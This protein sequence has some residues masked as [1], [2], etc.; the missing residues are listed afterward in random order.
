MQNAFFIRPDHSLL[1]GE[2]VAV[3]VDHVFGI[4]GRLGNEH[5]GDATP[6][7][8]V[9]TAVGADVD[10]Q[11]RFGLCCLSDG[12]NGGV[13][14]GGLAI[15]PGADGDVA[16]AVGQ[17]T[18]QCSL[19][20]LLELGNQA[21]QQ[22]WV[23][24][25][26][27]VALIRANGLVA[28]L[29]P[30][31]EVL[32][33]GEH[34]GGFA[35]KGVG[36]G[37]TRERRSESVDLLGPINAFAVAIRVVLVDGGLQAVDR[38]GVSWFVLRRDTLRGC[39]PNAGEDGANH[40]EDQR[41]RE[42]G[43]MGRAAKLVWSARHSQLARECRL[44]EVA[45]DAQEAQATTLSAPAERVLVNGVAA[46]A[47]A[48]DRR[49]GRAAAAAGAANSPAGGEA[50]SYADGTFLCGVLPGD[51]GWFAEDPDEMRVEFVLGRAFARA[52]ECIEVGEQKLAGVAERF[53]RR[54]ADLLFQL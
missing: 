54:D 28:D 20:V 15:F 42:P 43:V 16:D 1:D 2:V 41:D 45:D 50:F 27:H 49:Q 8:F 10:D 9:A 38:G 44:V 37:S 53:F 13:Q 11:R 48:T 5:R 40:Q 35:G 18:R 19:A 25:R 17:L 6:E 26:M 14:R 23:E 12:G 46:P 31:V 24:V 29:E 47:N 21:R 36:P 4:D 34:L 32:S 30:D 3:F 7:E 51:L 52:L 22:A 39:Q 33:F